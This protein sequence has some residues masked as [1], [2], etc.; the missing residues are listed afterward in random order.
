MNNP[1]IFKIK[2]LIIDITPPDRNCEVLL[3]FEESENHKRGFKICV[4][5]R[6]E[7]NQPFNFVEIKDEKKVKEILK[8]F[9]T[10][11]L[12]GKFP[13]IDIM[14]MNLIILHRN[15]RS[16]LNYILQGI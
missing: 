5:E 7:N 2:N 6:I 9:N 1:N 4:S 14:V 16:E 10:G 11:E 13:R 15:E 12:D 8:I 3:R